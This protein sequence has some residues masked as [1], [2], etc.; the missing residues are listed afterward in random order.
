MP[1]AVVMI[2]NVIDPQMESEE[3]LEDLEFEQFPSEQSFKKSKKSDEVKPKQKTKL[4]NEIRKSLIMHEEGKLVTNYKQ[5][6]ISA[7][8][9]YAI[10]FLIAM[11]QPPILLISSLMGCLTQNFI[12]FLIPSILYLDS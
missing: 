6:L 5:A 12:T 11:C 8:V 2:L 3:C 4:K 9:F 10:A 7:I 1:T